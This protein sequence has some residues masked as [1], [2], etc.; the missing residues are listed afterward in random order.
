MIPEE[1]KEYLDEAIRSWRRRKNK[2]DS[3]QDVLI[4]R[5]Y[6]DAF[7]SVRVSVF[8]STLP[9]EEWAVPVGEELALELERDIA[10]RILDGDEYV[11]VDAIRGYLALSDQQALV[12]IRAL[13]KLP[14]SL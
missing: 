8:G 1:L 5:C 14:S 10:V 4:A 12:G 11:L 2:A 9:L 3:D 6:I 13:L 7:Q